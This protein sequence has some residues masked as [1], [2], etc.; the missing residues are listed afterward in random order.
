MK[1]NKF[2]NDMVLLVQTQRDFIDEI[3]KQYWSLMLKYFKDDDQSNSGIVGFSRLIMCIP[4]WTIFTSY[5][6]FY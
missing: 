3:I 4:R 2:I 5:L 6:S 1:F